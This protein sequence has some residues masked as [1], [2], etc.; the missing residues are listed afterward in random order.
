MCDTFAIQ[1]SFEGSR[2]A[3]VTAQLIGLDLDSDLIIVNTRWLDD[4]L[5]SLTNWL[6]K[7]MDIPRSLREVP[8]QYFAMVTPLV[9]LYIR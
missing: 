2:F 3:V 1:S 5:M 9:S 4:R 6:D 7:M 8:P